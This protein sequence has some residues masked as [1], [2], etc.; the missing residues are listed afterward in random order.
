MYVTIQILH[1]LGILHIHM[2]YLQPEMYGACR[3][4]LRVLAASDT[5]DMR[6]T[7]MHVVMQ[8]VAKGSRRTA[9]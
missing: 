7:C 9:R 4:F 2:Y 6:K 1:G 3:A 5:H 8:H